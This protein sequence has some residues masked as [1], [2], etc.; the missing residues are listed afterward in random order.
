MPWIVITNKVITMDIRCHTWFF[1][2]LCY[3]ISH[4]ME[5]A[6]FFSFS[7]YKIIENLKS[8]KIALHS[9]NCNL[10]NIFIIFLGYLI[11]PFQEKC[12]VFFLPS[13]SCGMELTSQILSLKFADI[14]MSET[15]GPVKD[16]ANYCRKVRKSCN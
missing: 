8:R 13:N 16:T 10:S 2:D 6:F 11:F 7:F 12:N 9:N 15:L 3:K 1:L 5:N 14:K 4:F